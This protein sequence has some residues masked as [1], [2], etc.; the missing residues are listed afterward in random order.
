MK[1][2]R[3]DEY[4]DAD[5][6]TVADVPV[7]DP[8]AGQVLV[9]VKA[10]GINP[11]EAKIREG[12]LHAR[13]PATF[14]SG[15][16]SDLA[17]VVDRLGP[18]V[19]TVA[20]GDEVIG[21]VDTRS[22]QAEYA[23]VDADNLASKPADVP[24]EVAGALGVAGFTAWAAIRAVNLTAG[25]TVAVSAAA[26][27]VG[28]LTVQL[29]RRAGATVVGIAGPHNQEWLREHGAIPV[30]YGEDLVGRIFDAL[31]T[32]PQVDA[33]IDT[34]GGD[35]VEFAINELG[36][37]PSRVDTIVRFDAVREYGVKSEGNAVGA[38]AA[39]LAELAQLIA[40]GELEVPIAAT[41]PLDQVREAYERLATGH[42][43]GKIVLLP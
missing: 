12:Q 36:V 15:Q 42:I 6:L 30:R 34:H 32:T 38:S 14:P 22:A 23:V 18:G 43:R 26:G 20:A 21:W 29:A 4:G 9:R 40:A 10:A 16:G 27:G 37:E 2:V 3:F 13:W 39:N 11:G 24:W 5:V 25:D 33:F 41:Y 35:Y 19:T 8:G 31:L 17:G 7:P 1:A 28:S